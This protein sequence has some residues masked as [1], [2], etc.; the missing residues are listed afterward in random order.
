MFLSLKS[1]QTATLKILLLY[2]KGTGQLQTHG[3]RQLVAQDEGGEGVVT[4]FFRSS[5]FK[6]KW[7]CNCNAYGCRI[8]LGPRLV[9]LTLDMINKIPISLSAVL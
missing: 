8:P 5:R 3:T 1:L 6:T 9:R 2:D 7:Y 4:V